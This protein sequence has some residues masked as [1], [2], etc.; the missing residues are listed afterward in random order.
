MV[1]TGGITIY[2]SNKCGTYFFAAC[3]EMPFRG[4]SKQLAYRW[5]SP[6]NACY[7]LVT[8][9]LF[10]QGWIPKVV[11]AF[12][13]HFLGR[14]CRPSRRASMSQALFS[15]AG[16]QV[17]TNGRFWVIAEAAESEP[18]TGPERGGFEERQA[19]RG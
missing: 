11:P 19:G 13:D 2:E 10:I 17:I 9:A 15:L 8:T 14:F 3:K 12:G 16:F 7:R 4:Q 5:D 18:D 1:G 6:V